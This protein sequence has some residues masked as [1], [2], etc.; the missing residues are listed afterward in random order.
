MAVSGD[1]LIVT[2]RKKTFVYQDGMLF[3]LDIP[4]FYLFSVND[5][6]LVS[7]GEEL[8]VL[9]QDLKKKQVVAKFQQS[10]SVVCAEGGLIVLEWKADENDKIAKKIMFIDLTDAPNFNVKTSDK[11]PEHEMVWQTN[12]SQLS[13]YIPSGERML[14]DVVTKHYLLEDDEEKLKEYV[15]RRALMFA[16]Q[17]LSWPAFEQKVLDNFSNVMT[18]DEYI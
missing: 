14:Y 5:L 17:A 10:Y 13:G 6:M 1:R 2:N 4:S 9:G 8:Y 7:T 16:S 12:Y 18:R 15:Q 3:D 11:L